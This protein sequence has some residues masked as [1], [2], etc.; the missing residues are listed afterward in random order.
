MLVLAWQRRS[1]C[2]RRRGTRGNISH[3]DSEGGPR[4]VNVG[5][6]NGWVLC[7]AAARRASRSAV[8]S[9]KVYQTP[10]EMLATAAAAVVVA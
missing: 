2:S 10:G 8:V 1:M 3:G 5:A 6:V 4:I 7:I 9:L